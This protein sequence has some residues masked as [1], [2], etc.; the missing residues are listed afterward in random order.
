MYELQIRALSAVSGVVTLTASGALHSF[1]ENFIEAL[2]GKERKGEAVKDVIVNFK[3]PLCFY[4]SF[5]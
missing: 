1:N 4:I 5:I 3:S 2:V